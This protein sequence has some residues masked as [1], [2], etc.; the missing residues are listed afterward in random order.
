MTEEEDTG[1]ITGGWGQ[2]A[3]GGGGRRRMRPER[4][5]QEE[6]ALGFVRRALQE[7]ASLGFRSLRPD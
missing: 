1:E 5:R 2:A 7:S 4:W 3:G 6:K